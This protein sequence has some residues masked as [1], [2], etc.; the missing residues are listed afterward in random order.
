[1]I[2]RHSELKQ[3]LNPLQDTKSPF[4]AITQS[5]SEAK[6]E[7]DAAFKRIESQ[8]KGREELDTLFE[9]EKDLLF[10]QLDQDLLEEDP[11]LS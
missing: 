5:S 8:G 7:E 6:A 9:D 10:D 2:N 3:Q 4:S 11:I 1:M